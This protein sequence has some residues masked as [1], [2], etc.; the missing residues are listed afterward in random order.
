MLPYS[1]YNR[2]VSYLGISKSENEYYHEETEHTYRSMKYNSM[3]FIDPNV[4]PLYIHKRV[5][6]LDGLFEIKDL[7]RAYDNGKIIITRC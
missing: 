2:D 4:F 1:D 3:F 6:G 7:Y 5:L